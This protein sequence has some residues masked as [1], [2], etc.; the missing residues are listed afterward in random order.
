MSNIVKIAFASKNE[1]AKAYIKQFK[2]GGIFIA[3]NF[4]YSLGEE[5]FLIIGLPESNE[6]VAVSG[7]VNWAS[8]V[9]AVG[10]P[11]GVGVHF[12]SDKAGQDARSRIEIMLGGLLQ[13]NTLESYTF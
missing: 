5:L 13:N 11:S 2:Y 6:P 10:Y 9:S 3:G 7:K 1:L 8:P 12:N 4:N